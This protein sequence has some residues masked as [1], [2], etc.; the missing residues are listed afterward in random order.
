MASLY[1]MR[2][3]L[4]GPSDPAFD[5]VEK[6]CGLPK[7]W[8][9]TTPYRCWRRLV[10]RVCMDPLN[11]LDGVLRDLSPREIENMAGWGGRRLAF[12]KALMKRRKLKAFDEKQFAIVN[13]PQQQ[14]HAAETLARI[15]RAK[16]AAEARWTQGEKAVESL[17]PV[18]SPVTNPPLQVPSQTRRTPDSPAVNPLQSRSTPGVPDSPGTQNE[19]CITHASCNAPYPSLP[20]LPAGPDVQINADEIVPPFELK[21]ETTGLLTQKQLEKAVLDAWPAAPPATD[22]GLIIERILRQQRVEPG[23]AGRIVDFCAPQ[24]SCDPEAFALRR[25]VANCLY[26]VRKRPRLRSVAVYMRGKITADTR[27][28]GEGC[29]LLPADSDLEE[30]KLLI[31][32]QLIRLGQERRAARGAARSIGDV[33]LEGARKGEL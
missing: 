11:R 27:P 26:A 16:A 3:D 25:F 24:L 28:Y 2:E 1:D 23:E 17:P 30:A 18:E 6:D 13:W 5:L 4:D 14:P 8:H 9:K 29:R 33:L 22:S 21:A 19:R 31:N 12:F 10:G 20:V 7:P 32:A 15:E